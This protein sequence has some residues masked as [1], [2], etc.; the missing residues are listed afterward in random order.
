MERRYAIRKK[1]LVTGG[2]GFI[3][4]DEIYNLA[5]PESPV[6]YQ[7]D[8]MQT[9]KTSVRGAINMLGDGTQTRSFCYVS[10]MVDGV[11]LMQSPRELQRPIIELRLEFGPL[12]ADDPRHRHP[13]ITPAREHL[14][15]QPTIPLAEGLKPTIDDFRRHVS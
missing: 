15:W 6:H 2:A 5:Y 3:E 14:D 9:A 13:D 8:P 10:D 11:R 12:P 7:N 4:V 1:I